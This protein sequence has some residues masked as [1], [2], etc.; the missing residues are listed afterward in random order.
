MLYIYEQG[1]KS[2]DLPSHGPACEFDIGI[3][4][5]RY[6]AETL[7]EHGQGLIFESQMNIVCSQVI[8]R[9]PNRGT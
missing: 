8:L 5:Y 7:V 3:N 4:I 9:Q 2:L 6:G 1:E